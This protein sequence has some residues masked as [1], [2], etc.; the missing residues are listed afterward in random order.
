M[1]RGEDQLLFLLAYSRRLPHNCGVVSGFNET[2]SK[3][4]ELVNPRNLAAPVM[5]IIS[6]GV[7]GC[8]NNHVAN[9]NAVSSYHLSDLL[10]YKGSYVGN[11]S[12]VGNILS[13]LPAHD[14]MAGFSL[15]TEK[16]P[17]GITVHYQSNQ[18][19]STDYHDLW[20]KTRPDKL[21]ERNAAVLFSLVQNVD[22]INF[23][24]Q[25]IGKETYTFT[26]TAVQT[27]Y[28][29]LSR[30]LHHQDS[31]IKFLNT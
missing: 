20:N 10:K 2:L 24:V 29:D 3:G 4:C 5:L 6:L 21:L 19:G 23:D 16:K 18:A 12:A 13:V 31:L 30:I 1:K 28:G 8:G 11:N 22:V 14:Y 9:Q 26:R 7:V 27:K 17:F 15:Q 25:G